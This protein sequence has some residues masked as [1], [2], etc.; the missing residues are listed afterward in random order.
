MSHKACYKVP[1]SAKGKHR[2]LLAASLL[3]RLRPRPSSGVHKKTQATES[4]VCAVKASHPPF[5]ISYEVSGKELKLLQI[6]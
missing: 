4:V 5:S 1:S 6:L 2:L 3:S